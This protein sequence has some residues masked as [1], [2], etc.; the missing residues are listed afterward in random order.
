MKAFEKRWRC[1]MLSGS[2]TS[3][4]DPPKKVISQFAWKAALELILEKC[5]KTYDV[6]DVWEFIEKE[7]A[8]ERSS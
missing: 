7:L 6:A 3:F 2:P 5:K 8:D 1:G 4:G